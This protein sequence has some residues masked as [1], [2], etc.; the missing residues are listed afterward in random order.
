M[1]IQQGLSMSEADE[2]DGMDVYAYRVTLA[3]VTMPLRGHLCFNAFGSLSAVLL[4]HPLIGLVAFC[5]N[6]L[7]DA[8]FQNR[9][10]RL[11]AAP[12][13]E[14]VPQAFVRLA[15]LCAARNGMILVPAV[16]M[17][18]RGGAAEMAYLGVVAC[19]LSVL[20]VNNGTLSRAVFF[21]YAGPPL[22][23]CMTAVLVAF[24]GAPMVAI[25]IGLFTLALVLT[26]ASNKMS[27]SIFVL[28]EAYSANQALVV[29]LER[30]R[31]QAIA[32]RAAADEAREAARRANAAK[33]S[34][35]A[36]MSHEIRT[37]M[38]GV[39]GMA[40]LLRRDET[41]PGQIK[42]L[43]TLVDSGEYL[44]GILNDILDVSKID[45]GRL[46]LAPRP[47]SLRR[48]LGQVVD[49]WGA[50]ADEK[51]VALRLEITDAV[52]QGVLMDALRL[53]QVL[54]N[55]I[56]NALKFTEAGSV[57]V[58]IDA[59]P[60]GEA[61][62]LVR[63]SVCDTG[64]GIAAEHLATLFDRFSQGEESEVR[65]FGGTGLGLAIAKQLIELMGGRIWV[66]STQGEGSA[67]HIE[68]PLADAE[69]Q[70]IAAP[71][72][73][74]W[75]ES[76]LLVLD[77]LIVDD[78]AVNLLVLD[79]LLAAFGHRVAKASSGGEALEMLG[80]QAFDLV[81]MDIQMP[82]MTGIEAL[83]LLRDSPGPNRG[84]PVIALT[85]DVTSGGRA[86]YVDLGFSD[87]ASKPVQIGEL[88]QVIGRVM[89]PVAAE[90]AA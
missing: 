59:Q 32:E 50:R 17:A 29:E 31:D 83:R 61:S 60:T 37:P 35:L 10:A 20:S 40:Q 41:D 18:V 90:R 53:R 11:R 66:E 39:L 46:E 24:S 5:L 80:R 84:A 49:F 19:I 81:L 7:G 67:F 1:S 70:D 9:I 77:L 51:G 75:A 13:P 78:N 22:V 36:T 55:L 85:A 68:L 15:L 72:A 8:L 27:R 76:D 52:P 38:N 54:F 3:G 2:A 26:A 79:Q 30:A 47:E 88:V 69:V 28:S 42:R 23:A 63:M 65:R 89:S 58:R 16:A 43:D 14:H 44:L 48:F 57:R 71:P 82:Q 12:A 21:A 56:G 64:P 86:R 34:F 45:A 62:N 25:A 33:S 87:H 73:D 74:T 4:G 6:S